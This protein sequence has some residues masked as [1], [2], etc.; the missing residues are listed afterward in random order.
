LEKLDKIYRSRLDGEVD[1]RLLT[2][3]RFCAA[4]QILRNLWLAA[5]NPRASV[6][7]LM[8]RENTALVSKI[9][10]VLSLVGPELR[11]ATRVAYVEDLLTELAGPVEAP[12]EMAWYAAILR[13]KYLP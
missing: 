12:N 8:P 7:F 3:E 9:T 6:V 10:Q 2:A 1:P 11:A 13:E 4:Y 5:S